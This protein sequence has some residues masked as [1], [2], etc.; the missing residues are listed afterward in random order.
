MSPASSRNGSH[1][2]RVAER[3]ATLLSGEQ[4][5]FVRRRP[6]SEAA[7]NRRGGGLIDN[8]P[9]HWMLDWPTPMPLI[10]EKASGATLI[11]IDGNPVVDFCLGDTG[12][13]FGHGPAPIL[14]ALAGAA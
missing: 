6:H 10:V 3:A 7:Y 4:Q 14:R 8:V 13:M 12:A 5:I 11:D 9:L 2:A 1:N